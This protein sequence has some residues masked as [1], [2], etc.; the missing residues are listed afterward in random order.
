M[1]L[2]LVKAALLPTDA[3]YA[4]YLPTYFIQSLNWSNAQYVGPVSWGLAAFINIQLVA[5]NNPGGPGFIGGL[6]VNGAGRPITGDVTLVED[7]TTLE[8][9]EGVSVLLL[10]AN[11][12]AV[13]HTVTA[14][15]V[16][17]VLIILQWERIMFM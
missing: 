14:L 3:D 5:G 9:M 2:Y 4:N 12:N 16:L 11:N 7:I 1:G 8:P 13:T 10:D 15:T 6:V 17:I